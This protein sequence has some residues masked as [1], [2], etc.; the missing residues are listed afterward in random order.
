MKKPFLPIPTTSV[1]AK[2]QASRSKGKG[3]SPWTNKQTNKQT[4]RQTNIPRTDQRLKTYEIFFFQLIYFYFFIGGLILYYPIRKFLYS[5]YIENTCILTITG[6]KKHLDYANSVKRVHKY[7]KV[8]VTTRIVHVIYTN[9]IIW[10]SS[11]SH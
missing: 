11:S 10:V 3:A 2:N 1:H 4:N 8:F 5:N 7:I 6:N 9:N